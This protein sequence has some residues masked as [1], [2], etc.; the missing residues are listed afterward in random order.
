MIRIIIAIALV[1]YCFQLISN[2]RE[3]MIL[4]FYGRW[5]LRLHD[6]GKFGRYIYKPLGGCIVCNTTWIGFLCGWFIFHQSF[7]VGLVTG[8]ASAGLANFIQILHT[9]IKKNL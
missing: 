1:G 3:E 5:L 6:S 4:S 2:P 9:L 8:L 7:F